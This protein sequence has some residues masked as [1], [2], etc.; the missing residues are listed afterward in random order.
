MFGFFFSPTAAAA[1]VGC[2]TLG[3]LRLEHAALVQRHSSSPRRHDDVDE[4]LAYIRDIIKH[5][6]SACAYDVS[7][8]R[9][10][11]WALVQHE[12]SGGHGYTVPE[13]RGQQMYG[14]VGA[15]LGQ[16][17][18]TAGYTHM[19][20]YGA[21]ANSNIKKATDKQWATL[22]GHL[23]FVDYTAPQQQPA[24]KL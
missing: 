8:G 22:D 13:V 16:Q 18:M 23:C 5:N 6:P 9:P 11:S 19:F 1:A 4:R 12:G 3:P 24:A 21:L 10:L 14:L 2:V 7:S 17:A 20:A 15:Y